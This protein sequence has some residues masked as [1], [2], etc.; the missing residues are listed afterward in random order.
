MSSTVQAT[1]ST[2]STVGA[3]EAVARRFQRSATGHLLWIW[4]LFLVECVFVAAAVS[5]SL[6]TGADYESLLSGHLLNASSTVAPLVL[7]GCM[8]L[9]L[10]RI[11]VSAV[12]ALAWQKSGVSRL[13]ST[14]LIAW[15][16]SAN[17]AS[18][19]ASEPEFARLRN[20][21]QSAMKRPGR[22]DTRVASCLS[23]CE[24]IGQQV[25][26]NKAGLRLALNAQFRQS[27]RDDPAMLPVRSW[28]SVLLMM[29]IIFTFVGL[30]LSFSSDNLQEL[31]RLMFQTPNSADRPA[32]GGSLKNTVAGFALA[33]LASFL[34]YVAYLLARF[35]TDHVDRSSGNLVR[36]IDVNVRDSI[37]RSAAMHVE[38]IAI[39]LPEKTVK[40]LRDWSTATEIFAGRATEVG[41]AFVAMTERWNN[42]ITEILGKLDQTA[43]TIRATWEEGLKDLHRETA[44]S[45]EKYAHLVERFRNGIE[46]QIK[47]LEQN[48]QHVREAVA[49]LEAGR[50]DIT[51][52]LNHGQSRLDQ[53]ARMFGDAMHKSDELRNQVVA[54]LDEL[55]RGMDARILGVHDGLDKLRR[56]LAGPERSSIR[57]LLEVLAQQAESTPFG[58]GYDSR[59]R[60]SSTR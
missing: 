58:R 51:D 12:R 6:K 37:A 50:R 21:A 53:S 30:F 1:I 23:W 39:D 17:S 32:L 2:I 27:D 49:E 44:T 55:A 29:G 24:M 57:G 4:M 28:L 18:D 9:V 11:A 52:V 8:T 5:F 16:D 15:I 14:G 26:N 56:D 20:L 42:S 33:F 25:T 48:H 10:A 34:G 38:A 7:L 45:T 41:D 22:V 31:I 19:F 47:D 43:D 54:R 40:T 46:Q 13:Q 36:L 59:S 3:V 60:S 35:Q